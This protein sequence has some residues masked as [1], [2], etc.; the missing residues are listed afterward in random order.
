MC[1][2]HMRGLGWIIC[3][4]S[5]IFLFFIFCFLIYLYSYFTQWMNVGTRYHNCY[6][7]WCSL[8]CNENRLFLYKKIQIPFH[9]CKLMLQLATCCP[10]FWFTSISCIWK[11]WKCTLSSNQL[12]KIHKTSHVNSE[13]GQNKGASVLSTMSSIYSMSSILTEFEEQ[14]GF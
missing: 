5:S 9:L 1:D 6:F 8:F 3:S 2:W 12:V 11:G 7:Y 10:I 14:Q 4:S 13:I